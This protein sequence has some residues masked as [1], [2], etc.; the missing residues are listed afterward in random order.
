MTKTL[1]TKERFIEL[2]ASG[3]TLSQAAGELDIAYNTAGNWQ[4]ELEEDIQAAKAIKLEELLDKY[5]MTKEKRIEL[6]GERLKAIRKELAKREQDLSDVPTP[7][8][9]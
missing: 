3:L 1:A 2:R 8:L 6:F 7:K 9:F 5:Q 4:S